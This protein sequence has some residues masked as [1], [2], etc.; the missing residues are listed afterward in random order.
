[1]SSR[2]KARILAFQALYAWEASGVQPEELLAFP[3][4]EDNKRDALDP[5]TL[6][7]PRFLVLGCVEKAG[8]VD[9]AIKA[10]LVNWD[11]TRLSRVDLAILRL[12]A[13]SLMCQ[14][15][16]SSSITIDEAVELAKEFGAP[17][18]FRFVNGV[19]DGIRKNLE[20]GGPAAGGK[21]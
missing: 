6:L 16:I 10:A 7:F 13:Y 18:S 4:L 1:M 20:T 9:A 3:W 17:D 21:A 19:L 15:D 14:K 12:S 5:E 2:R 8:L 11:F